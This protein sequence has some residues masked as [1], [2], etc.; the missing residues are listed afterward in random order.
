MFNVFAHRIVFVPLTT[1]FSF[2]YQAFGMN[3]IVKSFPSS[4]VCGSSGFVLHSPCI[5]FPS[6]VYCTLDHPHATVKGKLMF[7]VVNIFPARVFR[8][9]SA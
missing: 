4:T 7:L 9:A 3:V 6:I 8:I 1:I 2:L 5:I